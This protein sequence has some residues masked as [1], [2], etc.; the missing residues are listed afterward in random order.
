[1][2][3]RLMGTGGAD[4]VPGFFSDSRVSRYAREHKGKDIRTRAAAVVDD[5]IKIDLGPDTWYQAMRDG[6]DARDWTAVLFTHSDADHF[7]PDELMYCMFPFN[8]MEYSGFTIYANGFICRRI[9]EKFPEWPFELVMTKSFSPFVHGGY[10]ISPLQAHHN[11]SEDS[12]NF[13]VQD[14]DSTLLYA[15][16]TGIWSEPTWEAL[17]HAQLDCMVLEC[18]EGLASTA[19]DGHLDAHEFLEVVERLRGMGVVTN[20]TQIVSTHH[21]HNGEAT[22]DE[23]V[24]FFAPH[25]VVVGYDGLELNF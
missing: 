21:S 11:P 19:Y 25:G 16:D 6:L 3:V 15:T 10:R 4:G 14:G 2:R 13:L 24:E 9:L 23:L 20:E 5:T 17:R 8:H 1:M 18:S 7:A 22:H 12:H